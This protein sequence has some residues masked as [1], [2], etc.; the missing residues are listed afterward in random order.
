VVEQ[1]EIADVREG[2]AGGGDRGLPETLLVPSRRSP[3][4][5]ATSYSRRLPSIS[6]S[7]PTRAATGRSASGSRSHEAVVSFHVAIDRAGQWNPANPHVVK[8]RCF[9][10]A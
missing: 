3:P 9:A 1:A 4:G 5:G 7:S 6:N 2:D 10:R 8:L